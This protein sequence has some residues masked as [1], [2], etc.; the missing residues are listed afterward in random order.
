MS[1]YWGSGAPKVYLIDNSG[2]ATRTITLGTPDKGG[3]EFYWEIVADPKTNPLTKKLMPRRFGFRPVFRLAY[4]GPVSETVEDLVEIVN[5]TWQ[6]KVEPYSSVPGLNFFASVTDF[7]T[8]HKDGWVAY[9]MVEIVFTGIE[10]RP[11]IP[12]FDNY[13]TVSRNKSIYTAP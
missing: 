13:Y 9:D 3:R 11:N 7:K 8:A 12:N 6:I 1:S 4:S 10:L 5:S 2:G